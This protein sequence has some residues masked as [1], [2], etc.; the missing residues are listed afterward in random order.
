MQLLGDVGKTDPQ[1]RAPVVVCVVISTTR[2]AHS[3]AT[4]TLRP[5]SDDRLPAVIALGAQPPDFA[6]TSDRDISGD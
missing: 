5:A 3:R 6:A 4:M 1:G 2:A